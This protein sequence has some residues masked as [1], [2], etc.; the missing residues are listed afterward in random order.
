M[1]WCAKLLPAMA[2]SDAIAVT[3][4]FLVLPI[5]LGIWAVVGFLVWVPLVIQAMLIFSGVHVR[6]ALYGGSIAE[7]SRRFDHILVLWFTGFVTLIR[8]LFLQTDISDAAASPA[9]GGSWWKLLAQCFISLIVWAFLIL[10]LKVI[11]PRH[12]D[13]DSLLDWLM[14]LPDTVRARVGH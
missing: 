2:R 4:K 11:A 8:G 6:G 12:V 1:L 10:L 5:L 7:A 9:V 3:L 14:A 13:L